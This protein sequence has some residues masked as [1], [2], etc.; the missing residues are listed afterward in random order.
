MSRYISVLFV[1]AL[2]LLFCQEVVGN[3]QQLSIPARVPSKVCHVYA[4]L[5]YESAFISEICFV[6]LL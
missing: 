4:F 2:S 1:A 6:P 5:L 3:I